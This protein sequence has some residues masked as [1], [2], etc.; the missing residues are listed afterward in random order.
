MKRVIT[1]LVL[2]VF[3]SATTAQIR[4][5]LSG[6]SISNVYWPFTA[7]GWGNRQGWTVTCGPRCGLHTNHDAYAQDWASTGQTCNVPF[8]SPFEGDV[9]FAGAVNVTT[10]YG[11]QVIVRATRNSMFAL[12]VAHLNRVDV[13]AGEHV[14]TGKPLGLIGNTGTSTACHAHVAIYRGLDATGINALSAG[15][16]PA[17]ATAAP[18]DFAADQFIAPTLTKVC[19]DVAGAIAAD[20]PFFVV[21]SRFRDAG[22]LRVLFNVGTATYGLENPAQVNV[23]SGSVA[24]ILATINVLNTPVSL[25]TI[26]DEGFASPALTLPVV[27]RGPRLSGISYNGGPRI[28]TAS[29]D[30]RLRLSGTGFS[31]SS[32]Q[33]A[34]V[35]NGSGGGPYPLSGA[36]VIPVG[37][38]SLDLIMLPGTQPDRWIVQTRNPDG[39]RSSTLEF[40]T[41]TVVGAATVTH[42]DALRLDVAGPVAVAGAATLRFHLPHPARTRLVIYD[43]LGREVAVLTDGLLEPGP[44]EVT[45]AEAAAPGVYIVRLVVAG[46]SA[47]RP[48][49]RVR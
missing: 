29:S 26:N 3:V 39:A 43:S 27:A 40:S 33:Q 48:F 37:T 15:R 10:D 6:G 2:W 12:R 49:V 18:F 16:V 7:G 13:R 44:H 14:W 34:S 25:Q 45:W 32:G 30:V 23:L 17:A 24:R 47:T 21:G 11:N 28:P 5:S 38:T 8:L 19:P 35:C 36:Q 9:L 22:A 4:L 1:F 20:Q 41:E 42:P 31:T 46:Q